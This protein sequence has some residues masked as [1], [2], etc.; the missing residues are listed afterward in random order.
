MTNGVDP[1]V[2]AVQAAGGS[3]AGDRTGADPTLL[4]LPPGDDSPLS[5]G[6]PQPPGQGNPRPLYVDCVA[7][8]MHP[9]G[10]LLSL[11][12]QPRFASRVR[13]DWGCRALPATGGDRRGAGG[14]SRGRPRA[15]RAP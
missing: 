1:G 2:D 14:A 3:Q 4:E 7:P 5:F 11:P 6:E 8:A 12:S 9:E 13:R 15:W 10:G